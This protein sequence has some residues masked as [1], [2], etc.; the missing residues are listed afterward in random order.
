M[1]LSKCPTYFA[2]EPFMSWIQSYPWK[3]VCSQ[4]TAFLTFRA[5]NQRPIIILLFQT[6]QFWFL[7]NFCGIN[8]FWATAPMNL[9]NQVRAKK[10]AKKSFFR[11]NFE[12]LLI[13]RSFLKLLVVIAICLNFKL[14]IHKNFAC[15]L[16]RHEIWACFYEMEAKNDHFFQFFVPPV[17][18][19]ELIFYLCLHQKSFM[20]FDQNLQ[21]FRQNQ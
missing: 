13:N 6:L 12:V 1:L 9:K 2:F 19:T 20:I 15:P 10:M 14:W 11:L 3:N 17:K 16:H 21:K 4:F 5:K 8:Q 7:W 18:L